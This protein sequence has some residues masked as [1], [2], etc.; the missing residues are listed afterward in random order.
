MADPTPTPMMQQYREMKARDPDALLLFRMGDFYEM[1][2][3][4]AVRAS[5]LLG[6]AVTSRDKDKGDQSVPMSGFPHQALETYLAKIVQA[7]QRAAVCEQVEDAKQAKGLVKRDIVRVVSPGTLTDEALLDPRSANYLAAVVESGSKMGLAWV[8]L[9]TGRFSLTSLLRTELADELARLS[10]AETL[11]SELAT[12]APW[13]RALRSQQQ[14]VVTTRPS[15][16]FQA[17][18]ARKALHEHFGV[19]TVEGFGVD[20]RGPEIQA[21][22]ALVAYLRETQKSSLGHIAR[23]TPYRRADVLAL[24]ETTR[25]SLELTRTLREGKREGS[26]LQ[27]IDQTATAMGARLLAEYV[28][29]PLTSPALIEERL[30]AV[31]ELFQDSGLRG[32][33]RHA[34]GEAY[35]LE[36]LAARSATGRAT[37]RDLGAL[38]RTLAIL[39]KLKARLAARRSKR[40]TEL[41]EALELCP[42]VR[43]AIESALVDEPPLTIK[44]GGLIRPGYHE[45]LDRLRSASKDGKA[46]IARYQSEQIRRTG[47]SGLKVGFNNVFGYYIEISHA[48]AQ[49]GEVP[50][51]YI[52]KQ[53]VKNAERYYTPELKEFE[54]EVRN[55]DE[56]ANALE[57]ELFTSLRDRVSADAPRLIQAGSALAQVDVLSSLAELAARQGYCRP[58]VVAEPVFEVEAGRHPVL[59][60]LLPRGEFV[61]ND[62]KL[63]PDWGDLLLI[64]GPN[65]AGKSTY[66]RQVALMAILAQIG[67]FVPARRARIGV[68]DRLFARVGATDELSRGQSTFMV[69]MTE[70]ANILNN[71]TKQS[72]VILDEIGRGTSTF[73]GVSLAWA[74]TEH[75]HDAVGCRA[76]FATHYHELVELEKTKP[77]LRNANVAVGESQGEIVF[78]HRIAPG[79]ADQSY[80]IHVARLAG[81]PSPV[82]DRAREILAFLEKQHGPD[83]GLPEPEGPIR[84]KVKSG[85]GLQGSLFAALPDPLLTELRRLDIDAVPPEQAV[86]LLRRLRELAD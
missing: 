27:V 70:T 50:A 51:D 18:Q 60:A 62:T 74:I 2:G 72:L 44:E 7:G 39:P 38:A 85:R 63:G 32:D 8:E 84:R 83:P 40:L 46:W 14:H 1:F 77:R 78:L 53:T 3:D 66:I 81:V 9:S 24:D 58:E 76:L 10:P 25:R 42:E 61:P 73:D 67:S 35:D 13:L 17:E 37:P 54:N 65:M 33:L 4:D 55:A 45:E 57:Y 31:D 82:L 30:A 34:L 16:D 28:T 20:D 41:E 69:E 75:L 49:R 21:A 36:R 86:A 43:S 48:Q 59:D 11:A 68:V 12:D 5:A 23:L 80:G 19:A 29:S 6:I 52:R 56:R 79:G 26:L 64:T 15:W 47:I 71:A 22:G